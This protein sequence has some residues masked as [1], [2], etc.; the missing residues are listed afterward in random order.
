[1]WTAEK[2]RVALRKVKQRLIRLMMEE[3]LTIRA[4]DSDVKVSSFWISATGQNNVSE[5][6]ASISVIHEV[7]MAEE[8]G[9][10]TQGT[11]SGAGESEGQ[12][13][14]RTAQPVQSPMKKIVHTA[15]EHTQMQRKREERKKAILEFKPPA[16]Y[17]DP[18][19]LA[20]IEEA[21]NTIGDY[22]LKDDPTSIA[23]EEDRMN[24]S[25]KRRQLIAVEAAVHELKENF[26]T[27]LKN[28]RD[29]K[30]RLLLSIVQTNR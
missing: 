23:S 20:A 24:A 21:K 29:L 25:K 7:E 11:E 30:S 2:G 8:D 26:N 6:T 17:S 16:N 27:K 3:S 5:A 19:D 4:I 12:Q 18:A 15:D 1:M 9:S 10:L 28:L 14:A 13:S 22:K